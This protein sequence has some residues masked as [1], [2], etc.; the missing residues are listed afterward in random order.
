MLP[1]PSILISLLLLVKCVFSAATER[2]L[3]PYFKPKE[4]DVTKADEVLKGQQ[5]SRGGILTTNTLK[6]DIEAG[7]IPKV[8]RVLEK[9][10]GKELVLVLDAVVPQFS[11]G[12]ALRILK[13][14]ATNIKDPRRI[15]VLQ[16]HIFIYQPWKTTRK[17]LIAGKDDSNEGRVALVSAVHLIFKAFDWKRYALVRTILDAISQKHWPMIIEK[18]SETALGVSSGAGYVLIEKLILNDAKGKYLTAALLRMLDEEGEIN[19]D[20]FKRLVEHPSVSDKQFARILRRN[21]IEQSNR[22]GPSTGICP[23]NRLR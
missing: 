23:C 13:K 17:T 22:L 9:L 15:E 16:T 20:N 7:R 21:Y 1:H 14:L 12:N 11:E 2:T 8:A 3:A 6:E 10:E 18:F 5:C 4:L 19:I